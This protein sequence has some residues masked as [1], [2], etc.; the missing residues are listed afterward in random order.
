VR[1]MTLA[2]ADFRKET[3]LTVLCIRRNSSDPKKPRSVIIPQASD[4]LESDDRLIVFGET[5]RL[6]EVS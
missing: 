1:G 6:D 4:R 5:K 2:E 3:G